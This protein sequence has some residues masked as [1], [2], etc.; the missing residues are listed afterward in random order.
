[1]TI[2]I[3]IVGAGIVGCVAALALDSQG[4]DVTV[5]EARPDPRLEPEMKNLRSINLSFSNRGINTL[6]EID[7][8]LT[9]RIMEHTVPL[10]GR[11]IHDKTG[12]HQESQLYGLFDEHNNSIDRA[13][14]NKLLIEELRQKGVKIMFSHKLSSIASVEE[15]RLEFEVNGEL[16][17]YEY[18]YIIG[19]DGAY[20]QFK[21]QLQKRMRMNTSQ[22][23]IDMAYLELYIGPK[24]VGEEESPLDKFQIHPHRLH[25]WPRDDFM[26][27]ALPNDDGSFTSTFF[28]TWLLMEGFKNSRDFV[29][30]FSENFP[31]AVGLLG[32]EQLIRAF[33]SY[34]RGPLM[35]TSCYPFHSPNGKAL[36]LGDS[37]HAMV[38]FYGQGMNCGVEDV[39]VLLRLMKEHSDLSECFKL[40]TD[41]RK[42]DVDVICQLAMDNY[43]EMASK[44]TQKSFLFRKKIDYFLGKYVNGRYFQ[45]IPFYSLISFR[46]DI[47]YSKAV[48]I[49]DKQ[50]EFL[51]RLEYGA[52]GMVTLAAVGLGYW[53]RFNRG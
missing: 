51:T 37:A 25:I 40:Y 20:S 17:V 12:Q 15:P 19:A 49:R 9:A 44:V 39:R 1:M 30:F 46:D 32:E 24:A 41:S 5:F 48:E 16:K 34:P 10:Y 28:A 14:F 18:D 11:M 26:L 33:D 52:L 8:Q 7:P 43:Q 22:N 36:L 50:N 13:L 45:W 38:P 2:G 29:E 6:N 42:K 21:Y 47:S 35:Q 3:G 23:Y 27:I 53:K 4:Y 31:D